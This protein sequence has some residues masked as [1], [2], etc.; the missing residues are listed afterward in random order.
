MESG[1]CDMPIGLQTNTI[2]VWC[3]FF[4]DRRIDVHLPN[5]SGSSLV[6]MVLWVAFLRVVIIVPPGTY[7]PIFPSHAL[8]A[9]VTLPSLRDITRSSRES[10]ASNIAKLR[11]GSCHMSISTL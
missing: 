4:P 11:P 6:D 1:P 3:P 7:L 5:F 10:Y 2:L 8:C 9:V